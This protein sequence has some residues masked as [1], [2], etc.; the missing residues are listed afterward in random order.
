MKSS[1][2]NVATRRRLLHEFLG[3]KNA[4]LTWKKSKSLAA[5]S[6]EITVYNVY[7]LFKK[8]GK[9]GYL[10]HYRFLQK[11]KYIDILQKSCRIL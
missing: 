5:Q 8:K 4:Y 3:S 7:F 2:Y 6:Q 11:K 10:K 9:N 1:N